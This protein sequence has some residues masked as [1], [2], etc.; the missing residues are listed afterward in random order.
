MSDKKKEIF[1]GTLTAPYDSDKYLTFLRE[2]LSNMEQIAPDKNMSPYN[3]FSVAVDHY[4]HIGNYVGQDNNKVAVFSV[5]L[6]DYR[7][8]ENARSM[9]RGFVKSLLEN[10]DCAGALVAFHTKDKPEKWRLSLVRMDYEFSKGKLS[11]KLTPAKRYSYL[12]G[13][14]E[15]C[16]TAQERLYPIFVND[17]LNPGLDELEEAFSVEAV[18]KGFFDQYREKYLDLKDYLEQNPQFMAEAQSRGFDSEQFAKKLLGQI[19][20]LY[21]IQKKGW[22]G[23]NAFPPNLTKRDYN[24]AFYCRGYG[25]KPKELLPL[26]KATNLRGIAKR[27]VLCPMKIRRFSPSLSRATNGAT[28]R[29]ILC[30]G[31]LRTA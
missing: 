25:A 13:K 20:F 18:T 6:K 17:N 16:H 21:F 27:Y 11:A 22:L 1:V 14:G 4:N 28:G 30:V 29:K 2:L 31:F 19:V 5:C 15:P 24:N 3:T 26:R 9:Q 7:N 10:S 8:I 12:V 23:V